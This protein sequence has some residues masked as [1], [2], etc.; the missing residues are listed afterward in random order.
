VQQQKIRT[1]GSEI[2][3]GAGEDEN[4]DRVSAVNVMYLLSIHSCSDM[5]GTL[6]QLYFNFTI[7][8]SFFLS[9]FI[10]K[11]LCFANEIKKIEWISK[12]L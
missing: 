8:Y 1:T 4:D 12:G 7:C 10:Q 9:F 2:R 11:S 3:E 5:I 6:S